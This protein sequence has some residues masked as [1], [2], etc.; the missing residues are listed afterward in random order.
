MKLQMTNNKLQTIP[1]LQIANLKLLILVLGNCLLFVA[2]FLML[3]SS[4]GCAKT[5]TPTNFGQT[6]TVIVT[7]KGS[8]DTVHNRYF[9]VLGSSNPALKTPLSPSEDPNNYEFLEPDVAPYD[10]AHPV[11]DYFTNFFDTWDGYVALDSTTQSF[12]LAHGPFV[13][14][15]AVNRTPFQPFPGG[16]KLS[17]NVQ[18]N[19]IYTS[20]AG[21]PANAYFDIITVPWLTPGRKIT[22]DHLYTNAYISTLSG[23]TLT[24]N[25]TDPFSLISDPSLDLMTVE[26]TVQ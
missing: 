24:I 26:V 12:S 10:S 19:Q 4:F 11:A 9:M 21:V 18:L 6:M 20:V 17:F 13:Q 22:A 15:A 25:D 2:C 16:N 23:S 8:A 1:K 14:G 5:V 3:T 7:L